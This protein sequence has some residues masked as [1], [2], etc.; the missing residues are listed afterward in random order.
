MNQSVGSMPGQSNEDHIDEEWIVKLN[1]GGEYSLSKNQAL[2]IQDAIA[3]GNRGVIMFKTFSISIPSIAEFFL[4]KRF[5]KENYQLPKG[6][7]EPW[8]EEDRLRVREKIK[9]IKE[10]FY[11]KNNK[12]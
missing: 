5:F 4:K 3:S 9:Q 1:T 11:N 6:D 8:T 10:K 12:S 7:E 2:I